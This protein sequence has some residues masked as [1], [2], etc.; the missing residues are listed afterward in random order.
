[1]M[2]EDAKGTGGVAKAAGNVD[3]S[4][5]VDEDGAEGFVLALEGK[6]G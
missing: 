5:F 2:L 1:M 4:L 3:R 6:L